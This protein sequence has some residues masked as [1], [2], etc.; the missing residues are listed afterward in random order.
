MSFNNFVGKSLDRLFL[1]VPECAQFTKQKRTGPDLRRFYHATE[2][3]QREIVFYRDKLWTATGG[4]LYAELYCLVPELQYALHGREQSLLAP[5][6]NIPFSH[7]QFVPSEQNPKRS[8]EL[9]SLDDVATFEQEMKDW[10]PS[11]ALPWLG[12]FESRDGVTRH[13][14]SRGQFVM[15]AEYLAYKG[16]EQGASLAVAAWVESL[17][18]RTELTLRKLAGKGLIAAADEAFLAKASIQSEEDYRLQTADW[19]ARRAIRTI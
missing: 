18:R 19:L 10:L 5:D 2:N 9:H 1:E 15:L 6:F 17:P 3:A 12:Q 8:W 4:V 14:Q 16:D 11:I 7:F 13:L